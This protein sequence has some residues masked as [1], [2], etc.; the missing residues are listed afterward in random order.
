VGSENFI[1]VMT[2]IDDNNDPNHN[3]SF[4]ISSSTP[5][6]WASFARLRDLE[7]DGVACSSTVL[8]DSVI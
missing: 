6:V 7:I 1:V 5:V 8:L 3:P 4:S 2:I